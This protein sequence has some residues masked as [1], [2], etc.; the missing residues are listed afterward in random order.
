MHRKFRLDNAKRREE[1]RS[2]GRPVHILEDNIRMDL[3]ETMWEVADWFNVAQDSD[4]WRAFVN[5]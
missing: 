5:M 3:R 1:K 2:L 4:Q